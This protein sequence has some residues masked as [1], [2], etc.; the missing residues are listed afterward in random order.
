MIHPVDP[1]ESYLAVRKLYRRVVVL[2]KRASHYLSSVGEARARGPKAKNP[3]FCVT[4][5]LNTPT[6]LENRLGM[7]DTIWITQVC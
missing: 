5:C 2:T 7:F 4:S 3:K 6:G 1:M